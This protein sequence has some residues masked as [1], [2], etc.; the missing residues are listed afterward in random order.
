MEAAA[1]RSTTLLWQEPRKEPLKTG[2][3]PRLPRFQ[4]LFLSVLILALPTSLCT[5]VL[6]GLLAD[7]NFGAQNAAIIEPISLLIAACSEA[8]QTPRRARCMTTWRR[9][10]TWRCCGDSGWGTIERLEERPATQPQAQRRETGIAACSATLQRL[11]ALMSITSK[12][13]GPSAEGAL[14]NIPF[15]MFQ[16]SAVTFS[17]TIQSESSLGCIGARL[18]C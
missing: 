5:L 14:P 11:L 3:A 8:K 4:F 2:S 9:M 18:L 17:L 15:Q 1:R 13:S 6:S 16:H 10:K 12:K 7:P